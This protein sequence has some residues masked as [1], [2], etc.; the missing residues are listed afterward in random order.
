MIQPE[1]QLSEAYRKLLHGTMSRRDFIARAAA[2]GVG[3]STALLLI[4]SP[5]A[6]VS[7][8]AVPGDRPSFGT[9]GQVRGA[10]GEL[11]L[12]Q[13]LGPT[14]L[15]SHEARGTSDY[16]A[17]CLVQEP[18]MHF[19]QDGSLL[20]NLVTEVPSIEN[21]GLSADLRTVTYRLIDGLFWSD[22][23]PVT[24]ED[25]QWTWQWITDETNASLNVDIY[26]TIESVE[27]LSRTE[28]TITFIEPTL[29][30][31]YPFTGSYWGA[32]LPKHIWDGQDK[33]AVNR[34]F[35]T[36]PIGTGPYKV[37]SFSEGDQIVYSINDRFREPN[38]PYFSS[39]MLRGG[40]DAATTAQAVLEGGEA[41]LAW[42][43]VGDSQLLQILESAGTGVIG[44]GPNSAVEHLA[45]NFSDPQIEIEGERSSLQA[46]HP[47]LSDP[48]VREAMTLA[49]DREAIAS[50]YLGGD[51]EPV[52]VNILNGVVAMESPNTEHE[53]DISRANQLLDD[54]GWIWT[55]DVR[56]KDGTE[57]SVAYHTTVG[58]PRQR[59]QHAVKESWESIGIRVQL[60]QFDR[61]NFFAADPVNDPDGVH[62]AKF[63]CDVQMF[64]MTVNTPM[65]LEFMVNWY[66]GPEHGNVAQ[67]AN[68]WQ[69]FNIQRYINPRFD[70]LYEAAMA[71]TDASRVVEL[72]IEMNDMLVNEFVV[73]PLVTRVSELY[74]ISNR[75]LHENVAAS[76]WEPLYWNIANWRT[77][78]I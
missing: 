14:I 17:S 51:L 48:V 62:Y 53:F 52:A 42:N 43:V 10:G 32:L 65:P 19:S 64:S 40:G 26:E 16:L 28:V 63:Y 25:V 12:L 45:F 4:N 70:A 24:A 68:G 58:G 46:P 61:S 13:W 76:P 55:G 9:D 59:T 38:K 18:I 69:A 56:S 49:I 6:G 5:T 23:E 34:S 27:V 41:D 54:A 33:D 8:Q 2:L 50:F 60:G 39:V 66:A 37:D 71:S 7:A 73:V 1:N 57:L 15:N 74:A 78:E 21:G 44:T 47:F 77:A 67:L 20:A 72:F 11:K 35:L 31:F 3:A 36:N 75:L 29:A 22:G 30:W